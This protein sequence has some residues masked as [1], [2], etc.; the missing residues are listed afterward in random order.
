MD[1]LEDEIIL[2]GWTQMNI[3]RSATTLIEE[4]DSCVQQ[5]GI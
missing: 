3:A 5:A 4:Q 1:R 2:A